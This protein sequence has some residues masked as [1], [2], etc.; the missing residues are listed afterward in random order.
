MVYQIVD[1]FIVGSLGCTAAQSG[2]LRRGNG[3]VQR[4]AA[5]GQSPV[6]EDG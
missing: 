6:K 2:G 4:I 3:S 1:N 5:I